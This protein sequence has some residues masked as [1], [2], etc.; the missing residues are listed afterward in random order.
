MSIS[1]SKE[2]LIKATAEKYAV[3]AFNVT[4]IAQMA[5]VIETAAELKA[6]VIIQ[7]SVAP[8]KQLTPEL[9]AAAFRNIAERVDI[10]VAIQLD[11]C[12]SIDLCKRCIDAGYTSIMIDASKE[13][14]EDNIRITKTVVDYAR[15]NNDVSIEGEL[16][17]VGGVEDQVRVVMSQVELCDPQNA[18]KF[19]EETGLD[20]FAPA[21]GTAHGIY[22]S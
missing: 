11:H 9:F 18:L 6:P 14:L 20:N 3:G 15:E 22:K 8:V 10:S 7:T 17:T 19:I 4:N 1:N 13:T 12:T 21:I 5:A 16:G 2:L